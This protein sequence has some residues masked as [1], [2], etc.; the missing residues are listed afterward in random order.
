MAYKSILA[1]VIALLALMTFAFTANAASTKGDVNN[2]DEVNI[3]DVNAVI[4]VI[5]CGISNTAA[6][7]NNDGEINIADVNAI[8]DIILSPNQEPDYV[9]LG[10]PSGTLWATCNVGASSPVD[11]GDYFAWGETAPKYNYNWS[12]Y[13]WYKSDENGRGITKYCSQSNYGY[14]SFVDN[15]TELDL[16]DDAA[17]V[18]WGSSWRMPDLEQFRELCE[19]CTWLW[20]QRDGV[21]GQLVTGPN[22]NT[23]FLPA[24]G[25]MKDSL[26]LVDGDYGYY[27]SRALSSGNSLSSYYLRLSAN[28]YNSSG[29]YRYHGRPVRPVRISPADGDDLYIRPH[30][31]DLGKVAIGETRTDE[32]TIFNNTNDT[33]TLTVTA[34]EPFLLKQEASSA[35]S[36]TVVVPNHSFA[37]VAVMF[38]ADTPGDFYGHV[39]FQN[40][41]FDE[42]QSVVTVH[43]C[44][45]SDIEQHEYVDLGLPSGTLWATTNVGANAPEE[46]GDYFAW[47]ETAPKYNYAW[48]TYKWCNGDLYALTKYSTDSMYSCCGFVDGKTELE[49]SDDAAYVNWGSSWRMPSKEQLEEL[50]EKCQ[51]LDTTRNGVNGQLVTGPNGNTIFL[52]KAGL[53]YLRTLQDADSKGHYWSRT[54]VSLETYSAYNLY[55][56]S[57][58]HVSCEGIYDRYF[59][60]TVRPVRISQD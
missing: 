44:A 25:Y 17:Y 28:S 14:D 45:I 11:R 26:L 41:A 46:Y 57:A 55:F 34:D 50:C 38:T 1:K 4:D 36:M 39:T 56:S 24:V 8:I 37:L 42:G 48:S 3:A 6:D 35:S 51:W 19:Y 49:P 52:P 21:N 5:L 23:M 54:L 16:E 18:N 31:L 40:P 43:A 20:T 12:T 53:R 27:W 58:E 32:V 9:D 15:K 60:F 30:N 47:G 13:K 10:L 59:G 29:S 7:V 22:G 2:D 33:V